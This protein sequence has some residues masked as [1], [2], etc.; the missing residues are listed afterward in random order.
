M[1]SFGSL[2]L[3]SI[4]GYRFNNRKLAGASI[5]F[6]KPTQSLLDGRQFQKRIPANTTALLHVVTCDLIYSSDYLT[7]YYAQQ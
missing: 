3:P 5:L 2:G 7:K 6:L 4:S 1:P